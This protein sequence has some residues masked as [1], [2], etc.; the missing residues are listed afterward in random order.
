MVV[1][2]IKYILSNGDI[3]IM[4]YIEVNGCINYETESGV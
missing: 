3:F 4:K 1:F 2:I